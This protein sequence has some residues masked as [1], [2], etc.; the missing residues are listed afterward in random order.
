M[1]ASFLFVIVFYIIPSGFPKI[2]V[3]LLFSPYF[4]ITDTNR[5][6]IVP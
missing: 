2:L 4:N 5:V 6:S 3:R 1:I